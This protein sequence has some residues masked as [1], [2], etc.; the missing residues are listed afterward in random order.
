MLYRPRAIRRLLA[1]PLLVLLA[2]APVAHAAEGGG[3]YT[4]VDAQGRR[5]TSDRPIADCLAREQRLLNKDG[6]VRQV[7][8]PTLSPE[9]RAAK[10]AQDRKLAEQKAAQADA[11]RRDRNLVA[12]FPDETTHRKAR[13]AAQD[14]VRLAMKATELRLKELARERKPLQDEAEFYKGR[15]LPARLKQQLDANDAGVDAQRQAT[16]NQQAELVRINS[17]YDAELSRLRRLWAGA[18]PGSLGGS[19]GAAVP[20]NE[21]AGSAPALRNA[22][23]Q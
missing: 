17:L 16:A 12:R 2:A 15:A 10:D 3:I 7:L 22:S 14:T 21:L 9:E 20:A 19:G 5:L 11:V 23:Q 8:P 1:A 13:E 4:C 18:A 6:S